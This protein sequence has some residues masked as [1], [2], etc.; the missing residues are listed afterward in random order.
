MKKISISDMTLI[1]RANELSF[2]D[3]IEIVRHLDALKVDYIYMPYLLNLSTDSL[4]IKTASA[5]I[6]NSTLCVYV[7]ASA[8]GV[9]NAFNC[10][11]SAKKK[12]LVV[13]LPVSAVQMEYSLHRKP[14][15]MLE[16]LKEL[17]ELSKEKT[18]N[19]EFIAEDST[20][21]ESGFL[22]D[23]IVTAIE[24]GANV[25][26]LCDDEGVMLP[27]EFKAYVENLVKEIPQLNSVTLGI[28]CKNTFNMAV[29]SLCLGI[30]AGASEIKCA[31]SCPDMP[32]LDTTINVIK[33]C[34]DKCD[35]FST[36]NY[37]QMHR[38]T[39]QIQWIC[40]ERQDKTAEKTASSYEQVEYFSADD[41]K[42]TILNACVKLGYDLTKEDGERVYE[43]FKRFAEKKKVS[44]KDLD[45]IIATVA[46]QV[47]PIY[48]VKSYVINNGNVIRSSAQISM[49]KNGEE[50][51][52]VSLGD[53][54]IDASFRTIE[55]IL[56][57]KFELD[58]FQIQ[59]VTEGKEAVGSALVRIISN[60]KIYSGNGVSTDIIGA[61]IRAYVSAVNKIVY[62]EEEK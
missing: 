31:C 47:P 14:P 27:D 57:R 32:D 58:D 13:S 21:A 4:L 43:E 60:G 5:F 44:S 10:V 19:V 56:G 52:G 42:E 8:D 49:E 35:C 51:S 20:R 61:S 41:N 18:E 22:K 2:K 40:G 33:N 24:S 6:K 30:R 26:T 37:T 34:G 46:L 7:G 45:A 53:G 15:K 38:I 1:K 3:K 16:L 55:Q 23:A 54:P 17:V 28:I 12:R 11:K 29:S 9:T 50:L 39:R 48:K 62:E 59:A 25:I 36:V